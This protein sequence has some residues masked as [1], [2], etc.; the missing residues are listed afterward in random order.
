MKN[1]LSRYEIVSSKCVDKDIREQISCSGEVQR[2][3]KIRILRRILRIKIERDIWYRE[4]QDEVLEN[5]KKRV[6]CWQEIKRRRKRRLETCENSREN[7]ED[8]ETIHTIYTNTHPV[9]Q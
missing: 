9:R 5:I 7:K 2:R 1:L 4:K 8:S 3:D 6:K